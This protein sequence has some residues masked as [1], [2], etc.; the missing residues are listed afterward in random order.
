MGPDWGNDTGLAFTDEVGQPVRP[1]WFSKEFR[2]VVAASGVPRIRLHDVRHTYATLALKAGV[3][4]KV[5]SEGLGH[6]TIA[7][8]LDL[9]SRVTPGMARGAADLVAATIF[10]D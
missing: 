10:G 1:E 9:Y 7:I 3:H 2:R 8:T 4:P 5:V 6:S